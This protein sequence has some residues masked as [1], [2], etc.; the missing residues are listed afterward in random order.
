MEIFV[1]SSVFSLGC[2]NTYGDKMG[3]GRRRRRTLSEDCFGRVFL[4]PSDSA[5]SP[6]GLLF[7]S[8]SG[9]GFLVG[10]FI[11]LSSHIIH[12]RRMAGF[13]GAVLEI[14]RAN[15]GWERSQ[16]KALKLSVA[17]GM[18]LHGVV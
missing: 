5:A 15:T 18:V 2:S 12:W 6:R 4:M 7:C 11:C 10:W 14:I 8:L 9:R 3:K 16:Q 13:F 17:R 1:L